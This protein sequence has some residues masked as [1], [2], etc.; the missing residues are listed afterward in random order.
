MP[1]PASPNPALVN[2]HACLQADAIR[3]TFE[4]ARPFA[5]CVI[6][7]FLTEDFARSLVDAFP[8]FSDG[9]ATSENG[10]VG[11]KA[12][13]ERIAGLAEPFAELDRL[14]QSRPFLDLAS[15]LTGIPDLLYDVDYF[16]GGTHENRH[17]QSLDT[18]IDFNRHPR[19]GWHRRL[20]L[21]VYLN[22]DWKPEWGGTLQLR[23]DPHGASP[24]ETVNIVP[25]F[26][27]CVIFETTE[28]SWHGFDPITLPAEHRELGR[29]SVAL[30]FYTKE[31]PAE[32][33]APRHSTVYVDRPLPPHIVP[34]RTLSDRDH[35]ELQELLARRDGHI[36]R[37]YR[38]ISDLQANLDRT[39]V[40]QIGGLARRVLGRL[41]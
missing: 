30:Y 19:T 34:G 24:T 5:H 7:D 3:N 21:I 9:N 36:R 28:H 27:R 6:D 41:R 33:T 26:N 12:T 14:V 22:T 17:G 11:G 18:H 8:A 2:P 38:D 4:H 32:Q 10:T 31:R 39:F 1:A 13:I 20:N 16:G 25:T 15:R 23:G 29:K 37:L 35:A 40:G